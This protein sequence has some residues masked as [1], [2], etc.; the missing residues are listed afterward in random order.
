MLKDCRPLLLIV[1]P[2][3]E[4][5]TTQM[6]GF[7]RLFLIDGNRINWPAHIKF[8]QGYFIYGISSLPFPRAARNKGKIERKHL[9]SHH[10]NT[11]VDKQRAIKTML[12]LIMLTRISVFFFISLRTQL[13]GRRFVGR[14][15][16]HPQMQTDTS[17]SSARRI[18]WN[19][20]LN[21]HFACRLLAGWLWFSKVLAVVV[22][23]LWRTPR[24]CVVVV[25]RLIAT[26]RG[27]M[28]EIE[29]NRGPFRR[30]INYEEINGNITWG[31]FASQ[32]GLSV[33][34]SCSSYFLCFLCSEEELLRFKA[35]IIRSNK[36][37]HTRPKA[38]DL[39]I[40][41]FLLKSLLFYIQSLLTCLANYLKHTKLVLK[42]LSKKIPLL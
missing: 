33:L 14:R 13:S 22:M 12:P 16:Q 20:A 9:S 42:L 32:P 31:Q 29:K 26:Q 10:K 28:V 15:L 4:E 40:V 18:A 30:A 36:G 3:Y 6:I 2:F 25:C 38:K 27:K 35:T 8:G 5:A 21:V 17:F 19:L 37:R 34:I 23:R 24:Q 1:L 41:L 39:E 7:Q 11:W